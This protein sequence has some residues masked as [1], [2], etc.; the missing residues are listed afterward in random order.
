MTELRHQVRQ[1]LQLTFLVLDRDTLLLVLY[2]MMDYIFNSFKRLESPD[3]G[4][5]LAIR[6]KRVR[7]PP[8][9]LFV[10]T[11]SMKVKS[12]QV[13]LILKKLLPIDLLQAH[14]VSQSLSH[15]ACSCL[16]YAH[17]GLVHHLGVPQPI[18][19]IQQ[20][21]QIRIKPR[22]FPPVLYN[23]LFL[24]L[25]ARWNEQL[26]LFCL[27]FAFAIHYFSYLRHHLMI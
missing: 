1:L 3:V 9:R 27:M 21:G 11:F 22:F 14:P 20:Q 5:H 25:R 8:S 19:F 7:V 13:R 24:L 6:F 18:Q 23:C 16:S 17:H 26:W 12:L 10:V 15:F 4:W 2:A